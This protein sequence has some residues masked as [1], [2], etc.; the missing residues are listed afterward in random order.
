MNV[1]FSTKKG[2]YKLQE[3]EPD[4]SQLN[5]SDGSQG[6]FGAP[7][8]HWSGNRPSAA[9][10]PARANVP[11][12][13]PHTLTGEEAYQTVGASAQLGKVAPVI[14]YYR[15]LV[16]LL[17]YYAS[18]HGDMVAVNMAFHKY[19]WRPTWPVVRVL[20]LG[21]ARIRGK[22]TGTSCPLVA[23]PREVLRLILAHSG[24]A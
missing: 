17:F 6:Y 2:Y 3:P 7:R 20:L 23:L 11:Y 9:M 12:V 13:C 18:Q 24:S 5:G 22:Q 8:G 10:T 14:Y 19:L 1:L 16:R 15:V 21:A 4:G